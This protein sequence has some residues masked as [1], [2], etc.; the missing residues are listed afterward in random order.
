[1]YVV[2]HPDDDL[3]F[4]SPDVLHDVESGRCVR[5]VFMT[6]GERDH[7]LDYLNQR[8]LGI[9]A[10]YSKMA[11]VANS[12][13]TADAG[14]GAHPMPLLTLVGRPSVSVVFMR[15]PEGFWG[16]GGTTRDETLKNLWLGTATVMH[17]EDGSSAYSSS[18]LSS[19]LTALMSAFQ[20]DR[21]GTQDYLGSFG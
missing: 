17:A 11:G 1:M 10:A 13:T 3:L 19:T 16:A 7:D 6:A 12:W 14:V 21:I 8:E 4:T 5:T 18:D 2:A 15:L 9:R 20:P